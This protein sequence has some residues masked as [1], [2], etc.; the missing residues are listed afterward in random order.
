MGRTYPGGD[1]DVFDRV[2]L[3]ERPAA[4]FHGL[5]R[6]LAAFAAGQALASAVASTTVA[7]PVTY[8]FEGR[9]TAVDAALSSAGPPF[10]LDGV[11]SGT[12]TFETGAVN[13][14]PLPGFGFY[15]DAVVHLSLSTAGYEASASG[16]TI[17]VSDEF[18]GTDEYAV[19][20]DRFIGALAAPAA[21]AFVLDSLDLVL[22]KMAGDAISGIG[23]PLSP[24][25]LTLFT[26]AEGILGFD[27]A[28][29]LK[30]VLFE[31]TSIT[32]VEPGPAALYLGGSFALLWR[33]RRDRP[34][35]P[36]AL[37]GTGFCPTLLSRAGSL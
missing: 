19:H 10:V 36:D 16:G 35:P 21:G 9:I 37:T 29:G 6:C 30:R 18:F 23:L 28:G 32:I 20:S 5:R 25:D 13:A 26:T 3:P 17:T 22:R 31:L 1:G 14:F 33:K 11:V 8:L 24:P 7:A 27:R 12:L 15:P 4:A 34:R 2:T